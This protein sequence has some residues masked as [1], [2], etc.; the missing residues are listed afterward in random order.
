[1]PTIL[2]DFV[3]TWITKQINK[4]NKIGQSF[5]YFTPFDD[6]FDEAKALLE[7]LDNKK[8][9]AMKRALERAARTSKKNGI[10]DELE[11]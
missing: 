2:V 1:M 8:S 4:I 7:E 6:I 5:D 10:T 9:V 11:S 3:Y